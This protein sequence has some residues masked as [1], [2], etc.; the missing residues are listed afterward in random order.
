MLRIFPWR[1]GISAT[2]ENQSA[3]TTMIVPCLSRCETL[4]IGP[5]PLSAV[6]TIDG[7]CILQINIVFPVVYLQHIAAIVAA[8]RGYMPSRIGLKV[9]SL[10]RLLFELTFRWLL[11]LLRIEIAAEMKRLQDYEGGLM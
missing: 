1:R 2:K 10:T 9:L 4:P 5:E 7:A 3:P 11:V 8:I 6:G